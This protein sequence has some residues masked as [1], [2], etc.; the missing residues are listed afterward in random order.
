MKIA[1]AIPSCT[2][3]LLVHD[4]ET[5]LF[6]GRNQRNVFLGLCASISGDEPYF[7]EIPV[8]SRNSV[9]AKMTCVYRKRV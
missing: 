4:R 8:C 5:S 1:C 9:R 7:F 6:K 3:G 2:G